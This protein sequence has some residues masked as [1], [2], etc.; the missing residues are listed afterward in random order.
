MLLQSN[1]NQIFGLDLTLVTLNARKESN[2]LKILW[3]IIL[4][5]EF[6][7]QQNY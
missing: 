2:T 6:Y 7:T 4:N 5:L 1:K 3:D